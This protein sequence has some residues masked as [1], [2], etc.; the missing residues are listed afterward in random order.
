MG[1]AVQRERG[2]SQIPHRSEATGLVRLPHWRDRQTDPESHGLWELA[3]EG[4]AGG[5]VWKAEALERSVPPRLSP[6]LW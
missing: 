3:L 5:G 4:A 6:S 2:K 1:G